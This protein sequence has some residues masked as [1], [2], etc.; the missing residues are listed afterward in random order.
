MVGIWERKMKENWEGAVGRYL[1]EIATGEE[2][3]KE[4]EEQRKGGGGIFR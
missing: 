4:E 2:W 1:K 3:K